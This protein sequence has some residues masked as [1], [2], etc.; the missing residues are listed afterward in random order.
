MT[1]FN[2]KGIAS[3]GEEALKMLDSFTEKP[4]II[5]MDHRMPKK[6]GIETIKEIIK[7]DDISKI[8]FCSADDSI[9]NEALAIGAKYFIKKPFAF[10]DLLNQIKKILSK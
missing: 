9:K 8:M 1:E 7:R 10:D 5:L 3:N 6:N 4:D 2:L